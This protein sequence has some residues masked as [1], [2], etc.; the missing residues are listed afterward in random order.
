MHRHKHRCSTQLFYQYHALQ[1]FKRR[2]CSSSVAAVQA[3]QLFKPHRCS[4]SQLLRQNSCS[5]NI[6]SLP[7]SHL[8]VS[9]LFILVSC[10]S[11]TVVQT[12]QLFG[13]HSSSG[14]TTV[15]TTSQLFSIIS[16]SDITSVQVSQLFK[17]HNYVQHS[18]SSNII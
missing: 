16:C 8:R 5:S 6:I 14:V 12:P 13:Q 2:S 15:L 11:I 18:C 1:L 9:Q 10:S 7:E 17:H 3:S 4:V